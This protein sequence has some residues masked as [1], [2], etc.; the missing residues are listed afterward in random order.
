MPEITS[1]VK[2]LVTSRGS[3]QDR[4]GQRSGYP[5]PLHWKQTLRS[6]RIVV[7]VIKVKTIKYPKKH[8][9]EENANLN[10]Y[11]MTSSKH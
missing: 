4:D 9:H 8:D 10:P 11:T 6:K 2:F 1:N 5:V 3:R 7:S